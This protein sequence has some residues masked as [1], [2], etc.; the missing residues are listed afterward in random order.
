[1]NTR[2]EVGPEGRTLIK[3]GTIV[4]F[5]DPEIAQEIVNAMNGT[6]PNDRQGIADML[7]WEANRLYS[8]RSKEYPS[9]ILDTLAFNIRMGETEQ[10]SR[11]RSR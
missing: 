3:Y 9:N 8:D 10:L 5:A 11:N 4:G 6:A 7:S 2:W 1:M